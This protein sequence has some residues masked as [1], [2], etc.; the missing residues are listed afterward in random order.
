MRHDVH[1]AALRAAAKVAFSVAFLGGCTSAVAD[2]PGDDEPTTDDSAES[3]ESAVKSGSNKAK[4]KPKPKTPAA[5]NAGST[6]CHNSSGG[7]AKPTCDDLINAA[8]PTE[9]NYPGTKKN[10]SKEVQSCCFQR[11]VS[12]TDGMATHR[13]DCCANAGTLSTEDQ[14]KV[15][16]ACTP[17]GPPVPPSMTRGREKLPLEPEPWIRALINVAHVG[18]A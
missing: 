16:V 1:L 10:V 6:A 11:L 8:F 3:S 15:F 13:W 14:Q 18:V 2:L 9:G 7:T 5:N 12:D 17:W 4:P